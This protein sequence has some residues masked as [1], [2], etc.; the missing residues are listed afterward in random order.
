MT[1]PIIAEVTRGGTIES[2]HRGAFCVSRSMGT[3]ILA[4]GGITTPVFPRSAIKAFQCVP[5]IESGAADRYNLTDE[6][7]ALCC[8][9]HTGEPEHIRVAQSILTKSDSSEVHLECGAHLP[10]GKIAQFNLIR[11]GGEALSIHNNC[12]GKHAGMLA[13]ATHLGAQRSGYS[14]LHHVVQKRIAATIA[15]LCD[16]DIE[17]AP[18]GIDGC[19]LPNWALP[20]N[21]LALGFARLTQDTHV[22]GQRIIKSVRDNPFMVAGSKCFDTDIMRDV[23]RLFVKVGAE[24]VYCGC[25]PHAKLGF[26]LKCDDGAARA[27]EVAVAA[28]LTKLDCWT[29]E[30]KAILKRYAAKDMKNWRKIEVGKTNATIA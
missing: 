29:L 9:S 15:E 18:V 8:A 27:A 1:N 26:A 10:N 3:P 13:L 28:M 17:T 19:S 22:A 4:A 11:S 5:L 20:L 23:P 7:I 12:S 25:I 21:N 24:G 16:V 6:E 14:T 2:I 30:E